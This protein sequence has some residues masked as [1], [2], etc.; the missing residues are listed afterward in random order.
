TGQNLRHL[1]HLAQRS[2]QS[3][4]V[5]ESA[6]LLLA[7][8]AERIQGK[9]SADPLSTESL[10]KEQLADFARSALYTADRFG[11]LVCD[12]LEAA[13]HAIFRLSPRAFEE[14]PALQRYGLAYVLARRDA[15]GQ[16]VYHELA[17]RLAELFTFA[18]SDPYRQLRHDH[19]QP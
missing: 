3:G 9:T 6:Q 5:G 15:S 19:L 17:M 1:I 13:V 10:I 12:D 4:A 14:L 8:S 16:R 7:K 18:L 11:L 2:V